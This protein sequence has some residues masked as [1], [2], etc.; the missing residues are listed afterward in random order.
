MHF[1]NN[2]YFVVQEHTKEA[3]SRELF[4]AYRLVLHHWKLPNPPAV[5][6]WIWQVGTILMLEWYIYQYRGCHDKFE[7]I[8]APWL[9]THGLSPLGLVIGRMVSL[10]VTED[11]TN[12]SSS[13]FALYYVNVIPDNYALWIGVVMSYIFCILWLRIHCNH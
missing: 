5:P 7:K 6:K 9:D 10:G 8:W 11:L 1:G 3:I 4:Q 12:D 2:R 13:V